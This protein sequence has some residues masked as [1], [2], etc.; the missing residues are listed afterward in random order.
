MSQLRKRRD[1]NTNRS[2]QFVIQDTIILV[3]DDKI[4]IRRDMNNG[5]NGLEVMKQVLR[6]IGVRLKRRVAYLIVICSTEIYVSYSPHKRDEIETALSH[7]FGV[8]D[9]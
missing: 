7:R 8:G 3:N 2:R 6:S 1:E 4:Y 9:G 5:D